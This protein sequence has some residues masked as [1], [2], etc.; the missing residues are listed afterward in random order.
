MK[1]VAVQF[2]VRMR[3]GQRHVIR[4]AVPAKLAEDLSDVRRRIIAPA[5]LGEEIA[6]KIPVQ[7]LAVGAAVLEVDSAPRVAAIHGFNRPAARREAGLCLNREC[8]AE[9]VESEERVRSRHQ[10]RRRDRQRRN[11][12]PAHDFAERLI[13][14]DA[15][16]VNRQALR[17]AEKRRRRVA[18]I[19]DVGLKRIALDLVDGDAGE[20]LV[21]EA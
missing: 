7:A 19:V 8:P 16:H 21:Q 3:D 6:G 11:Q 2:V 4:I 18:A 13:E 9:R 5:V 20:P 10:R 15:V 12:I 14:P 17:R 1:A